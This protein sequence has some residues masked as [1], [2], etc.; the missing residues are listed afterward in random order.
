MFFV[1]SHRKVFHIR[2][3]VLITRKISSSLFALWRCTLEYS[4]TR[5]RNYQ[6][7]CYWYQR[8]AV[9][10][11]RYTK[12]RI[13]SSCFLKLSLHYGIAALHHCSKSQKNT[14]DRVFCFV[15]LH[16]LRQRESFQRRYKVFVKLHRRRIIVET[17][18]CVY[19][20]NSGL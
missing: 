16:P 19:V 15:K 4:R 2:P 10:E 14:F 11:R 5:M 9:F 7:F 17:T 18:S 3:M 20:V 6:Y 8:E 13:R 1:L 12:C